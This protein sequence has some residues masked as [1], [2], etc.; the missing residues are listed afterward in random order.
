MLVRNPLNNDMLVLSDDWRHLGGGVV[1]SNNTTWSWTSILRN[2]EGDA[3]F[4]GRARESGE[5]FIG[6]FPEALPEREFNASG[7][8]LDIAWATYMLV[9]NDPAVPVV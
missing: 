1:P 7:E 6:P 2:P 9:T 8:N 3:V 5:Y 4:I